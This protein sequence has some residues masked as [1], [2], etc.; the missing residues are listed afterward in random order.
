MTEPLTDVRALLSQLRS[1]A[2]ETLRYFSLSDRE[3][4]LAYGPGKWSI[5]YVLHH[6]ADAEVVLHER[7][8]RVVSEPAPR[9]LLE[10]L[11]EDWARALE[12]QSVPLDI[13]RDVYRATRR[14]IIHLAERYYES[15]GHVEW[16]HSAM[17]RRT[18][19]EEFD[20]VASHNAKHLGQIR[21]ALGYLDTRQQD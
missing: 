18:L 15:H 13:S 4:E 10:F 12:Y 7:I 16:V 21:A 6:L 11:Q 2:D 14:S 5:R 3:L 1:T 20:K 19:A 17:G 8:K 9:M